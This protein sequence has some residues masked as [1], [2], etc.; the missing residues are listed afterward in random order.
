MNIHRSSKRDKILQDFRCPH[1]HFYK[2]IF[3]N[4]HQTQFNFPSEK[5]CNFIAKNYSDN[6][7]VWSKKKFIFWS[8]DKSGRIHLFFHSGNGFVWMWFSSQRNK[9]GVEFLSLFSSRLIGFALVNPW[10]FIF[11]FR[12]SFIWYNRWHD[13]K[14][15]PGKS[16]FLNW[17]F[18]SFEGIVVGYKLN[19][20]LCRVEK[21]N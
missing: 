21:G 7:I 2:T 1:S 18:V 20:F 19:V 14:V 10:E 17:S 11:S 13:Y 12:L 6:L 16:W 9:N 3:L 4:F 8:A 5:F 15:F